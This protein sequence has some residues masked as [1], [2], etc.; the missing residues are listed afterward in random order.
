M[1]LTIWTKAPSAKV[2]SVLSPVLRAVQELPIAVVN[3]YTVPE[4]TTVILAL[5][6]D[7]LK[8]LQEHKVIAKNRTTTSYR[9]LP[10]KLGN[11]PVLVSYSPDIGEIDHGYYVDLLTDVTL[12]LRF[13]LTG[14]WTPIY[15]KY[16]YVQ[17][18][19]DLCERI[20]RK[21]KETQEAV[22]VAKDL[23]TLGLDPYALPQLNPPFP[24]AYIVC[25]QATCESGKADVVRFAERAHEI[26]RL[27][28]P[29]FREQ[30]EFL[31][32][33]DYIRLKGANF[34]YDLH[35]LWKRGAFNC[36][37]FS[38]DTT[39]VGSLLDENRSNGLDV[40]VKIYVPALAGY[41]DKFD[42]TV[43]K[44]RMDKVPPDQLLP[45]AGGDVDGDLQVAAAMKRELLKDKALTGFYV[46][47]LHPAARAFEQVEQTGIIV[48]KDAYAELKAD[49]TTEHARLVKDACKIMGGRM[50][51]P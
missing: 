2:L 14:Q 5:G 36:T 11:V 44:A 12:A 6:G 1:L 43:D 29:A 39:I 47:I 24:G 3:D 15:G 45:Y 37:N 13:C 30:I 38:F 51:R 50:N 19:A 23:E 42:R 25:M 7:A 21:N 20:E 33:C 22:D 49:L 41:S 46:N 18:F 31:L 48:D 28:D 32:R 16:Q 9:T 27:K 17:D 40:H 4:D 8:K 35:W 10:Q 34:K 26:E